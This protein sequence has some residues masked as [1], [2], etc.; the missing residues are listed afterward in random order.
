MS[1]T[2]TTV[3]TILIVIVIFVV[4]GLIFLVRTGSDL[5]KIYDYSRLNETYG[6]PIITYN[7]SG[8]TPSVLT[9][10]KGTIVTFDTKNS[11][12]MW[13]ASDIHPKHELYPGSG[14]DQCKNPEANLETLFDSCAR[15]LEGDAWLFT[16]N[17]VGSWTYHNHV[18]P[19][20][21]GTIIV[22]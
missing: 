3:V 6:S 18:N 16:F 22:K 2:V 5:D 21:T 8:Y 10:E 9:V 7:E 20:H 1:K 13:I 15:L 17:Q 19:L 14:I 4:I 12:G 11:R